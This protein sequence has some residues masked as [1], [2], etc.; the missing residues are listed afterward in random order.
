M[1]KGRIGV[2]MPAW[3]W[4]NEFGDMVFDAFGSYPYLV[5]S[6]GEG[7]QWRDVDVR[8]ILDDEEYK[9]YF[10]DQLYEQENPKWRVLCMAF[11]ELGKRITG[12][13]IDFQ[14][15][16][17]TRGNKQYSTQSRNSLIIA[18]LGKGK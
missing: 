17:A 7:K 6:A 9:N 2:G 5:G 10:G 1:K 3:L 15:Q 12:L 8:L 13:P 16:E 11:S 14:I 18:S 4:L